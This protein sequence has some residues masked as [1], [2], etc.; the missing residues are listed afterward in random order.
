MKRPSTLS[1]WLVAGLLICAMA[2]AAVRALADPYDDTYQVRRWYFDNWG[3]VV[4]V[5]GYDC[6]GQ[7]LGSTPASYA[8]Y[9]DFY[10]LCPREGQQYP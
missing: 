5:E 9:R 8:Y 2:G 4:G 1:A 7:D 6:E 10:Y 3:Y